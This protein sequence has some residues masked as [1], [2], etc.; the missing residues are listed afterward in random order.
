MA[1]FYANEN[2][3]QPVV[4]ALRLLGHDVLTVL[5]TGNAG[6][7]WSDENVL[8][9]AISQNRILLTMNRR[10]F[11]RLQSQVPKHAGIVLCTFDLDFSGQA[12][13]IHDA[14][15]K[16]AECGGQLLTVNRLGPKSR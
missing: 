12:S 1:R 9:F 8:G 16:Q 10:H 2:F 7:S 6:V 13:R 14:V 3:P 5:E 15:Q 4:E 11:R